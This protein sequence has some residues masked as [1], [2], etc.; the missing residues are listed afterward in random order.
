MRDVVPW[1]SDG[2]KAINHV[3]SIWLEDSK[4]LGEKTKKMVVEASAR[5]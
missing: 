1:D 3:N 5:E 4:K 2:K